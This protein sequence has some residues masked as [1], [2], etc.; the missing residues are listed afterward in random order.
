ML[1]VRE[2]SVGVAG[3]QPRVAAIVPGRRGS[4]QS[5]CARRAAPERPAGALV[6]GLGR[7]GPAGALSRAALRPVRGP[8]RPPAYRTIAVL[9]LTS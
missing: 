4:G 7:N 9:D 1:A 8:R 5:G 6:T 2:A 3:G